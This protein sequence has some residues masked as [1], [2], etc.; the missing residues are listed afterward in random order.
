MTHANTYHRLQGIRQ[1]HFN[2]GHIASVLT[3]PSILPFEGQHRDSLPDNFQ[4]VGARGVNA[5]SSKL[6]LTLFPPTQPFMRLEISPADMDSVM[7]EAGASEDEKDAAV[8]EIRSSLHQIESQ[9]ASEFDTEGWRP[10]MS[11]AMRLGVVTGNALIYMR[12]DGGATRPATYDL[13]SYVVQRDPEFN[14]TKVVLRQLIDQTVAASI[15]EVNGETLDSYVTNQTATDGS[16]ESAEPTVELFT[17]AIRL[18]DGTF[19]FWQE[20]GGKMVP[21]S[22]ANYSEADL[23]LKVFAFQPIYGSSYGRGYVEEYKGDLLNLE[24]LSRALSESAS[25]AA[26]TL[27]LVRPGATTK[28]TTISKAPNGAVRQGD[29]EDVS[30]LRVEKGS[31]MSVAASIRDAIR[32]DLSYVFL[33]NSSVQRSGERVTAE[34]IRFVAQE[35]EDVLGNVYAGLAETYQKPIVDFFFSRMKS[36][37]IIDIPSVVKPIIAT[38]L[39]SISR[40]HRVTRITEFV[41]TLTQLLG[42]EE[43]AR[44]IRPEVVARD[45]AT[46]LNLNA[47]EYVRSEDEIALMQQEQQQQQLVETLGPNVVNAAAQG[48]VPS[49]T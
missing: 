5:L 12:P 11:E 48:S 14:L 47:E 32:R 27:F 34:E 8:A 42:P 1:T 39:E 16:N 7:Q 25:V 17:G 29:A 10:A 40:G 49:P 21:G 44:T 3:I 26:K 6:M 37:G 35:L 43:V 23:P 18:S 45:L 9:A 22:L 33:L 36:R 19:K 41:G 31:D 46:G 4:S 30:V 38:G 2:V 15:L 20:V 28:A 24:M 13:R